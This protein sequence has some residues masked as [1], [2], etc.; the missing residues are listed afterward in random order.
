MNAQFD[1][2]PPIWSIAS[3]ACPLT[4]IS[5][6]VFLASP[7]GQAINERVFGRFYTLGALLMLG[8]WGVVFVGGL[9]IGIAAAIKGLRR[10]ESPTWLPKLALAVNVAPPLAAF[11]YR[12][13]F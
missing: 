11:L 13:Y 5:L 6:F 10:R 3:L 7:Q 9:A 1:A 4:L 2:K 12:S 8:A